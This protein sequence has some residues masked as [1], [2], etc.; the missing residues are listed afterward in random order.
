[1]LLNKSRVSK[2]FISTVKNKE[3]W[4]KTSNNHKF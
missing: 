3:K 2:Q 4:S 1:M